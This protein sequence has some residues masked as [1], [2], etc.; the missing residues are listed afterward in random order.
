MDGDWYSLEKDPPRAQDGILRLPTRPGFG[1]ELDPR[2]IAER[3]TI[4]W[5]EL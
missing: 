2:K 1:I 4:G 3:K 5:R